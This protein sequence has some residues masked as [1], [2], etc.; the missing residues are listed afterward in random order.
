M[1]IFTPPLPYFLPSIFLFK[2]DL[3]LQ[4]HL[5]SSFI[6]HLFFFIFSSLSF[7][8]YLFY[9][10]PYTYKPPCLRYFFLPHL[11]LFYLILP[12]KHIGPFYHEPGDLVFSIYWPCT[13]TM[14]R[15]RTSSRKSSQD[16][17]NKRT[18]ECV[19]KRKKET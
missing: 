10:L 3:K 13:D 4:N 9:K 1:I 12:V 17:S 16:L 6:I 11:I 8:L 18:T 15:V 2:S 14:L 5:H 7:L 19:A